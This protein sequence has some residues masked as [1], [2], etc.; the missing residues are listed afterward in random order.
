MTLT[1]FFWIAIFAILSFCPFALWKKAKKILARRKNARMIR[2]QREE[3]LEVLSKQ[4]ALAERVHNELIKAA[5]ENKE[6]LHLFGQCRKEM[7]Y[8]L[9]VTNRQS[10]SLVQLSINLLQR[11]PITIHLGPRKDL[12]YPS[13]EEFETRV[14]G[15]LAASVRKYRPEH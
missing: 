15:E 6:G 12:S 3:Q 14:I 4:T 1:H 13:I 8:H 5:K 11:N 10:E 7:G 2:E 9:K